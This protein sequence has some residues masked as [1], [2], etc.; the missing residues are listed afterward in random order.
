MLNVVALMGR[1][2]R[3]PELRQTNS[4]KSV[5]SFTIACDRG[6]KSADGKS[7]A[8]FIDCVAWER[9][10]EFICQYFGKGDLIAIDGRLQSRKYQ[11]KSGNNRT[12]IEV[13]ISNANFAGKKE[14]SSPAPSASSAEPDVEYA[15]IEDDG[16][17]P[18]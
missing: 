3:D 11:D 4:G 16:D 17:L 6:F 8:D 5:A 7:Q 9:S 12:A 13:R 2:T 15:T 14:S 1:L 18:F 10:A